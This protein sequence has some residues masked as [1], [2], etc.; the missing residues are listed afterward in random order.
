MFDV[1]IVVCVSYVFMGMIKMGM[2]VIFEICGNDDVYVILWGGKSGL[3]Y[4]SV[5]IE[6]ICVV[7]CVVKLCE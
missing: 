6:V 2:V 3:N 7:L 1:I 5:Y 4:D